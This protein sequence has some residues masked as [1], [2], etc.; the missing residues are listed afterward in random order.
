MLA[1]SITA[2]VELISVEQLDFFCKLVETSQIG[3]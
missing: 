1:I 2:K 3:A